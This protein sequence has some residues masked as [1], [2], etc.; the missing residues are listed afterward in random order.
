MKFQFLPLYPSTTYN[1]DMNKWWIKHIHIQMNGC[2]VHEFILCKILWTAQLSDMRFL[3]ELPD[4]RKF[5]QWTFTNFSIFMQFWD[6]FW[7][8]QEFLTIS[9]NFVVFH[10]HVCIQV[11]LTEQKFWILT[12][13]HTVEL[14]W[15]PKTFLFLFMDLP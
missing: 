4:F 2:P 15:K 14:G 12:I 3:Q 1:I 7:K 8:F 9:G 6:Y 13:F 10:S 11:N 5:K